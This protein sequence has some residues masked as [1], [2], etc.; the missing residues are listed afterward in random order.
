MKLQYL[1]DSKDCF[2]WDYLDFLTTAV[3][4]RRLT[5]ALMLT[6]DDGSRDG[7]TS[8]SAYPAGKS[9]L[10]FCALLRT[11]RDIQAIRS[12]PRHTTAF[13]ELALHGEGT[14]V[15]NRAEYFSG[16]DAGLDQVV[17]VDPDN[18]FEP[19]KS[20]GPKHVRYAD[21]AQ[22]LDQLSDNSVLTV[23][24]HFRRLPFGDD[25]ARIRVRLAPLLSTAIHW[26]AL[27]FVTIAKCPGVIAR[28]VGANER[29]ASAHLCVTPIR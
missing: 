7:N 5:V 27:M 17:L 20:C 22:V 6:P 23:F 18:G 2:K 8:A 13:Y 11:S 19:K 24:Q 28:V 16:F 12:L 21:V 3:G 14:P 29:Y 1:G 15:G 25:F 4:F 10:E 9:V 26:H